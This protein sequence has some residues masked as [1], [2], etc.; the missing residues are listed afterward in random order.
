MNQT[1]DNLNIAQQ[2]NAVQQINP[3]YKSIHYVPQLTDS[4]MKL[5]S[6]YETH[7]PIKFGKKSFS[8]LAGMFSKLKD[9]LS[10]LQKRNV[11][12]KIN[13]INC[14]SCYIGMTVR[15]LGKRVNEHK[16]GQRKT[17]AGTL[18]SGETT[19]LTKHVAGFNHEFNFDEVKILD[20]QNDY[21]KLRFS[22]MLNIKL[23]DNVVNLRTDTQHLSN[24]YSGIL[25]ILK[26][27]LKSNFQFKLVICLKMI[28]S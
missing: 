11:I 12:Y 5:S 3:I 7:R 21:F 13:C 22:E 26:K 24:L 28:S 10:D 18:E 14:D 9:P 25:C 17:Q 4:L 19:A 27:I 16:R 2:Q 8:T 15:L 1:M 6:Q 20:Q 23:H